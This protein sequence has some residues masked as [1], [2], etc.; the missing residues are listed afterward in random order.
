M[1]RCML[2]NEIRK[3]HLDYNAKVASLQ[4][5]KDEAERK[6]YAHIATIKK[7]EDEKKELAPIAAIKK[8]NDETNLAIKAITREDERQ[9]STITSDSSE[10]EEEQ[11]ET[12]QKLSNTKKIS[13]QTSKT[14]AMCHV[15]PP[16][17]RNKPRL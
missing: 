7:Q 12:G 17:E 1:A 6:E 13:V 2:S 5:E 11:E 8:Q 15:H 10:E 14:T 9:S 16:S 4:K 3:I